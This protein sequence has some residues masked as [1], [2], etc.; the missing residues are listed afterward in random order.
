MEKKNFRDCFSQDEYWMGIAF[1]LAAKSSS[2]QMMIAVDDEGRL[3]C[4]AQE[5]F[6]RSSQYEHNFPLEVDIIA[7][8]KNLPICVIYS[9]F[10]PC[11]SMISNLVCAKL[12]RLV[13]YKTKDLGRDSQDLINCNRSLILTQFT[14][15]LNWMRD[16]MSILESS[17]IFT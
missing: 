4:V 5:D 17:G 2:K 12:R 8:C 15:N 3:V 1:F 7:N 6:V 9:T 16:Y 11:Y 14:G 10:T 13:F